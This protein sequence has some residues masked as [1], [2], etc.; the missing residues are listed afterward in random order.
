MTLRKSKLRDED[1]IAA[2][3]GCVSTRAFNVLISQARHAEGLQTIGE[4]RRLS[5]SELLKI[6]WL[7]RAC[8]SELRRAIGPVIRKKHTRPAAASGTPRCDRCRFWRRLDPAGNLGACQRHAPY[9]YGL[10]NRLASKPESA[11]G[12]WPQTLD[13]SWCGDF[14][15][16]PAGQGTPSAS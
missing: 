4:L 15:L 5:D 8:L 3:E 7:G 1:P 16:G 2:L 12:A 14:E 9:P 6:D 13:A 10:I 11:V